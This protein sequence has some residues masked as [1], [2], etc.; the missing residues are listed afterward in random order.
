VKLTGIG[1][2]RP[3]KGKYGEEEE[4]ECEPA[5]SCARAALPF[6]RRQ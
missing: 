5:S 3:A 4:E 1:V 2:T 6:R